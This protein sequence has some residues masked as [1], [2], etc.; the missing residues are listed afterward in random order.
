MLSSITTQENFLGCYRQNG[1]PKMIPFKTSFRFHC[2]LVLLLGM[3]MLN[4]CNKDTVGPNTPPTVSVTSGPAA[5]I[6]EQTVVFNWSGSDPDGT[7]INYLYSFDYTPPDIETSKTSITLTNLPEGH[8]TFYVQAI[9]NRADLS[10][11]AT[12][13]FTINLN[14]SP[15]KPT[16]NTIS[17]T[18]G[19]GSFTVSWTQSTDPDGSIAAYELQKDTESSFSNPDQTY[20]ISTTQYSISGLTAGTYYF[21]VRAKDNSGAYSQWSNVR[22]VIVSPPPAIGMSVSSMNLN[23]G[24][25]NTGTHSDQS[26]TISNNAN[27]PDVLS[28]SFS[29]QS[30][31]FTVQN[32]DSIFSLNPGQSITATVRFSSVQ[33]NEYSG[34]MWVTHNASNKTSPLRI[35][36]S[37]AGV[38][39]IA[40]YISISEDS[41][42]FGSVT[43]GQSLTRSVQITNLDSSTDD[44]SGEIIVSGNDFTI[45][46]GGGAFTL[47][48]GNS[49]MVVVKFSPSSEGEKNG[50]LSITHDASNMSTPVEIPLSGMGSA[51]VEM[52]FSATSLDF[53]DVDISNSNSK[54]LI[55]SNSA[56]SSGNLTGSISITGTGYAINSGGGTFSLPPGNSRTIEVGFAPQSSGSKSGY[57]NITH[58]ATNFESPIQITLMGSGTVPSPPDVEMQNFYFRENGSGGSNGNGDGVVQVGETIE[59]DLN[60]KNLGPGTAS[61]ILATIVL[62]SEDQMHLSLYNQSVNFPDLAEDEEITHGSFRIY[63]NSMPAG[64]DIDFDIYIDYY[65]AGSFESTNI[66]NGN[67]ISVSPQIIQ[68]QLNANYDSY[69]NTDHPNTNYGSENALITGFAQSSSA[70]SGVSRALIDFPTETIP[71]NATIQQAT[72]YLDCFTGAWAPFNFYVGWITDQWS[73][74]SVTWNNQPV[75]WYSGARVF[76]FSASNNLQS[77]DISYEIQNLLTAG[78]DEGLMLIATDETQFHWKG[79]WSREDNNAPYIIVTYTSASQIANRSDSHNTGIVATHK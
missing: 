66:F 22:S 12:W 57:L 74:N 4:N 73:E 51:L 55:I 69:I 44:V 64:N 53:G 48:P 34:S 70:F 17:N 75:A 32:T 54:N 10:N 31:G 3:I 13:E 71:A 36:L 21:R 58:N 65:Y 61:N 50:T 63:M 52:N 15:T 60:L 5:T 40:S 19:D 77:F 18:D 56:S 79:F 20:A 47:T 39:N 9:D 62:A 11:I 8:H 46:S 2:H 14:D 16:L 42:D 6:S 37:G 41:I 67:S 33:V 25:V 1:V 78:A 27:S 38:Q 29:T 68:T 45:L 76:S 30:I 43:I 49:K 59:I 26:L 23:F 35:S 28:G 7:I 72:L 24:E